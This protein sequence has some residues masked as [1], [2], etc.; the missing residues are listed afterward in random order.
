MR[1]PRSRWRTWSVSGATVRP[2]DLLL[3]ALGCALR[4]VLRLSPT[5]AKLVDACLLGLSEIEPVDGLGKA[6]V[7]VDAGDH[8]PRIDRDQLDPDHRDTHVPIDHQT[9]VEDQIDDVR[10]P[11]RTRSPLQVVAR[12]SLGRYR[13]RVLL[14][15]LRRFASLRP[16]LGA[17]FAPLGQLV[18]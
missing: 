14:L 8:D 16:P 7:R 12:R 17:L 15:P 18:P 2:A 5:L 13:H 3:Q 4:L 11:A 9:L 6:E 10:Q 1:A